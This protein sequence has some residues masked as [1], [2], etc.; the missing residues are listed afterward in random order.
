MASY[1]LSALYRAY[2]ACLNSRNFS[3]L[4]QF[5]SATVIHNGRE[6]GVDGYRDMLENDVRAIPDLKFHIELLAVDAPMV[7]SRLRF[8]CTPSGELF[9]LP[10][11]GRRVR[12]T[13]NVFYEFH[14]TRI[15]TV[16]SVI[17]TA[18]IAA[19]IES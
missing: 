5:V 6:L 3:E 11:N 16:W 19:Q 10:V 15:Q 1:D 12:F 9:G 2:I 14:Q 13:E 18:A 4:A 8:D 17:D 7:C